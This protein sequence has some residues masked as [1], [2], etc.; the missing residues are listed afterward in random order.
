MPRRWHLFGYAALLYSDSKTKRALGE[1]LDRRWRMIVHLL[2]SLVLPAVM[3]FLAL[4]VEAG[5]Y[6]GRGGWGAKESVFRVRC[7]VATPTGPRDVDLGTAFG[8][9]SGNVLS[10]SHVVAPCLNAGG[11]LQ[12]VGSDSGVSPATV[13]LQDPVFDLVLLKPDSGF[14]KSPLPIA[15]RDTMTMGAQVSSW[16][17]PS[18]YSGGVALLT[19]GHL[20]GVVPDPN[21]PSIRRWV[22]NAAIN[23]GNSGGPLR[24]RRPAAAATVHGYPEP[25]GA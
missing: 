23:K 22:V 25:V 16:G 4:A 12:L 18:G 5:E 19:V 2:L 6:A 11:R 7:G 21:P 14:V 15:S 13:V 3:L 9:K 20:A 8:H 24:C 1:P 10:A 17:F